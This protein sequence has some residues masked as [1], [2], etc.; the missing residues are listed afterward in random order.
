MA[1]EPTTDLQELVA[2]MRELG[3]TR[4][5]RGDLEIDLGPAPRKD[6]SGPETPPEKEY[7]NT[8]PSKA[9]GLTAQQQVD[10]FNTVI[11]DPFATTPE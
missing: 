6:I 11:E 1:S 7:D 8:K 3:V 2:K 4:Y 9:L 5:K 10:L